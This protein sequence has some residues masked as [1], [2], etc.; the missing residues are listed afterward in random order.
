MNR[1]GF[2][3]A[4]ALAP[5]AAVVAP[6]VK[7]AFAAGGHIRP[8]YGIVGQRGPEISNL[9]VSRGTFVRLDGAG[10]DEHIRQLARK[11]AADAIREYN[12]RLG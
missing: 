12:Q 10:G 9:P 7:P 1:R 11:G 5:V 3:S 6:A 8:P 4:L 2:L